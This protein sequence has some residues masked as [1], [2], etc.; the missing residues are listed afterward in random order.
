MTIPKTLGGCADQLFKL[1]LKK[2]VIQQQIDAIEEE[3]REIQE[4]LIREL[5]NNGST[6]VVGLLAKVNVLRKVVPQVRDWDLLYKHVLKSKDFSLLQRR[7][8]EASWKEQTEN[9]K[10]IPGVESFVAMKI[11]LTKV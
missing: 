6:G 2:G 5:P 10:A 8:S 11:S 1:K 4:H 9:G 7:V 3:E